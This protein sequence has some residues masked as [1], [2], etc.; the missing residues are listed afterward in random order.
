MP[1][2]DRR[3]KQ[4]RSWGGVCIGH[5]RSNIGGCYSGHHGHNLRHCARNRTHRRRPVLGLVSSPLLWGRRPTS[6][7]RQGWLL[8]MQF[9][10]ARAL[11]AIH[12]V[13]L[14]TNE[15]AWRGIGLSAV[16]VVPFLSGLPK[17]GDVVK[18]ALVTFVAVSFCVE[19]FGPGDH[20]RFLSPFSPSP[21]FLSLPLP[22]ALPFLP[23]FSARTPPSGASMSCLFGHSRLK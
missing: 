8:H 7:F 20:V 19:Y 11:L 5:H 15:G 12:A 10:G 21:L 18:R 3:P 9:V 16:Y 13:C 23:A 22:L 14:G 4:L 17:S 1:S 6:S 2:A